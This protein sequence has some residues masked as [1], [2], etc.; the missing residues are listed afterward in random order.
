[1]N[2]RRI[3]IVEDEA[4]IA[5]FVAKGLDAARRLYEASGFELSKEEQGSQW[6]SVV[7]EQQFT[8]AAA[9]H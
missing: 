2:P 9:S 8:R 5:S 3:L 6:G 4:R 7:T 1:M